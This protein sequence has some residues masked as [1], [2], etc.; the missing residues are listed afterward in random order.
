MINTENTDQ[1]MSAFKVLQMGAYPEDFNYT[2]GGI[3]ASTLGLCDQL[4]ELPNVIV[5]VLSNPKKSIQVD[6]KKTKGNVEITYLANKHKFAFLSFLRIGRIIKEIK[7]FKPHVCHLH[8][9]G[10]LVLLLLMYLKLS[11]KKHLVTVHG[12][13]GVEL[14]KSFKKNKKVG[15]LLQLFYYGFLELII[16]NMATKIIVDT[17]YVEKW[18]KA[19]QLYRNHEIKIVP[20]GINSKFYGIKDNYKENNVLSIGSISRRKG[21]EFSIASIKNL[22]EKYP[23]INYN[24]IGFCHDPQ[25]YNELLVLIE[26]LHLKD[27]VSISSNVNGDLIEKYL[28]EANVFILHSQ[29]ESQGIVFCEAMACGKPIV[30]TNIGGV[31]FVVKS[32]VNGLL[33]AF[34][35]VDAFALNIH[36]ILE[37]KMLRS[38]ISAVN[39]NE[40]GRYNWREITN[41]IFA[42]YKEN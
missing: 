40:A 26:K 25:Y 10:P 1:A 21:Y 35:D 37:D 41:S 14:L 19:R 16:I 6:Y 23:D 33:S 18:V 2:N 29:E 28:S 4:S 7:L 39:K 36:T 34:G 17:A 5:K 12:I 30:A 22:V 31:P 42:I 24:I 11:K 3:E 32:G 8:G 20:Q 27:C 15:T 9:T 38:K 13:A